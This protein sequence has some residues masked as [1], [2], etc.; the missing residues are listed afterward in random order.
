MGTLLAHQSD[1]HDGSRAAF[2]QRFERF[3]S[4]KAA[5]RFA[6]LGSIPAAELAEAR[7]DATA[8]AST[9]PA[10]L[11]G[12]PP[13]S[14]PLPPPAPD[15]SPPSDDVRPSRVD[16]IVLSS[17]DE[18]GPPP[19]NDIVLS[20]T[21]EVG[22]TPIVELTEPAPAGGAGEPDADGGPSDAA[23]PVDRREPAP[24][25]DNG[26]GPSTA[27]GRSGDA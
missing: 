3:T 10:E 27:P 24:V 12:A 20:S 25:N 8:A 15:V 2:E 19:L 4:K 1:R 11:L 21:D 13:A 17:S 22:P 18:T 26:S 16:D 23:A 6:R 9:A 7:R 5:R 14:A